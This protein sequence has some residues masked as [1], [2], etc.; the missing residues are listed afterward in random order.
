MLRLNKTTCSILRMRRYLVDIEY[1]VTTAINI[2]QAIN[3]VSQDPR[4]EDLGDCR[5]QGG[6]RQWV[7]LT[8]NQVGAINRMA[9]ILPEHSFNGAE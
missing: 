6:L 8:L 1:R 2:C 5:D 7:R 3:P 9:E 4:A